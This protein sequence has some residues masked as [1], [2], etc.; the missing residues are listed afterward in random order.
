M[1]KTLLLVF[2]FN[3]F[4]A[5]PPSPNPHVTTGALCTEDNRDFDGHRYPELIPHCKRNVAQ[6]LKQKIYALYGIEKHCQKYYTIDHFIPLSIGGSNAAENIWPEHRDVKATRPNLEED[7]YHLVRRG[8]ISQ[9][10][11][12]ELIVREKNSPATIQIDDCR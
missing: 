1:F 11:A 10:A 5:V 7:M 4:A 8:E 9:S 12:I 3:I 6:D 2:S